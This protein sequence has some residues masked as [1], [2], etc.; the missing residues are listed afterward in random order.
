M[1]LNFP[2]RS[3]PSLSPCSSLFV[4]SQIF[5]TLNPSRI[6]GK[7]WLEI[8]VWTKVH[9]SMIFFHVL[10]TSIFLPLLGSTEARL[11]VE[12]SCHRPPSPIPHKSER[13]TMQSFHFR[14]IVTFGA[15]NQPCLIFQMLHS[16]SPYIMQSSFPLIISFLLLLSG[17]WIETYH[18]YFISITIRIML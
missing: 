8:E 1:V 18:W 9:S 3:D 15:A 17:N 2:W 5:F 11:P 16:A 4:K 12:K 13:P 6:S 7:N 10:P 14:K